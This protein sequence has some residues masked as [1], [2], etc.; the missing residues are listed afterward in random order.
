VSTLT[1]PIHF[2][3]GEDPEASPQTAAARCAPLAIERRHR[4]ERRAGRSPSMTPSLR[5]LREGPIPNTPCH[6]EAGFVTAS[7]FATP[8]EHPPSHPHDSQPFISSFGMQFDSSYHDS[9]RP[10]RPRRHGS[11]GLLMDHGLRHWLHICSQMTHVPSIVRVAQ[12]IVLGV[13][14]VFRRTALIWWIII[15]STAIRITSTI[16]QHKI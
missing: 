10:G 13:L 5:T 11:S 7:A 15:A 14:Y 1:P 12:L 8:P 4:M 3:R 2:R 6:R 16:R 9:P